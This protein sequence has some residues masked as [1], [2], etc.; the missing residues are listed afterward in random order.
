MP[1][2]VTTQTATQKDVVEEV[3]V[4]PT[5]ADEEKQTKKTTD[6]NKTVD[7]KS[8]RDDDEIQVISLIPNVSYKDSHTGDI[9]KWDKV[10]HI[11]FMPF[12]VLK[13]MWRSSKSYFKD[14]WLKPLDDRVVAKFGLTSV[15][16]KYEFLMDESNYTGK[17]ISKLCNVISSTPN[18]LKFSICNKIKDLIASNKITDIRVIRALEKQLKLDLTSLLD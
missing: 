4:S 6:K 16:E 7:V 9:Y 8:L 2:K 14:M 13:N 3:T 15:F 5:V 10:G 18:G 17:S 11:E 12:E 1:E